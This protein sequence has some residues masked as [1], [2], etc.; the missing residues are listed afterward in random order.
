M[1]LRGDGSPGLAVVVAIPTR[2]IHIGRAMV[3]LKNRHKWVCH[4]A[5]TV[6]RPERQFAISWNGSRLHLPINWLR[7]FGMCPALTITRVIGEK[8]GGDPVRR[9][10]APNRSACL[11]PMRI[12][13]VKGRAIKHQCLFGNEVNLRARYINTMR[14]FWST[15]DALLLRKP[16]LTHTKRDFFPFS[17]WGLR[18]SWSEHQIVCGWAR[19]ILQPRTLRP[20]YHAFSS[21]LS[22]STNAATSAVPESLQ[23]CPHRISRARR[24]QSPGPPPLRPP[25]TLQAH[26]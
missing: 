6:S 13:R 18:K 17:R 12:P 9:L 14:P 7:Y 22:D 1:N 15:R 4:L 10:L 2:A 23:D 26:S 3:R 20:R 8:H 25:L 16:A 24:W 11:L 21:V 5:A 19:T